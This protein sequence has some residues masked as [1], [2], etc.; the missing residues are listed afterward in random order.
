MM[1]FFFVAVV[2]VPGGWWGH[3]STH[4][5]II[6]TG[7][8]VTRHHHHHSGLPSSRWR[9]DWPWLC[10]PSPTPSHTS[11]QGMAWPCG[12]L[13]ISQFRTSYVL[14]SGRAG[15]RYRSRVLG[16]GRFPGGLCLAFPGG[17]RGS[18]GPIRLC[19]LFDIW[20]QQQQQPVSDRRLV[21][22]P[23]T[24]ANN[25]NLCRENS[26]ASVP[27]TAVLKAYLSIR[28]LPRKASSISHAV[29][30]R[31]KHLGEIQT[32]RSQSD[33]INRASLLSRR[34]LISKC[35]DAAGIDADLEGQ[36]HEPSVR[37][38][39]VETKAVV[40]HPQFQMS[41]SA[42]PML[43]RPPPPVAGQPQKPPHPSPR[44]SVQA[45]DTW[46]KRPRQDHSPIHH[47]QREP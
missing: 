37:I 6:K 44:H 27:S 19:S 24:Q 23:R 10:R 9:H 3:V 45:S 46:G 29:E 16:L 33:G 34:P 22:R 28:I 1:P 31:V 12:H 39:K 43:S 15:C 41:N 11:R 30:L 38:L 2:V 21:R 17:G 25:G 5:L 18:L 42:S 35:Q 26:E 20:Q 47:P 8:I 32:M 36:Q 40:H 13:P 4:P 14:S 7:L